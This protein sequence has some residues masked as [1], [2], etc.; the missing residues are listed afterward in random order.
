M[1]DL[2][3]NGSYF[4]DTDVVYRRWKSVGK[5]IKTQTTRGKLCVCI[6]V[7]E[8]M[9]EGKNVNLLLLYTVAVYVV[10]AGTSKNW[11]LALRVF[12][13]RSLITRA[14]ENLEDKK[15][16][17]RNKRNVRCISG[18]SYCVRSNHNGM[19]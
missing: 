7:E 6:G 11:D 10:A 15:K 19:Y 16:Y 18:A 13:I 2:P 4:V 12:Y 14:V 5:P 8:R 3:G 9:R 17:Y 1:V